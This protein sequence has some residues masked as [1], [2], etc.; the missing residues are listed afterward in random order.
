M[1]ADIK[2]AGSGIAKLHG[3]GLERHAHQIAGDLDQ[4]GGGSRANFRDA[5]GDM[6]RAILL[7]A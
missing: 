3:C 6:Q 1:A 2:G 7:D 4:G 5:G